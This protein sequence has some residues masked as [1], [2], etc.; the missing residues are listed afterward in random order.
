MIEGH[1]GQWITLGEVLFAEPTPSTVLSAYCRKN[2]T[3]VILSIKLDYE[4][5]SG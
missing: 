1:K 2:S 4:A 5:I 3:K